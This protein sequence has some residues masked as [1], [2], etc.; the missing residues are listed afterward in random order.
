MNIVIS[1]NE[2]PLYG[3]RLISSG[4]SGSEFSVSVVATRPSIPI[5]GMDELLGDKLRWIVKAG[6]KSWDEIGLPIPDLFFQAGWYIDS[7]IRLGNEV[8]AKGG[9]VILLSDNCWR[10]TPRQWAGAIKYRLLY[11]RQFW[12]VWVPGKSGVKLMRTFG[13]PRAQIFDGLY[14]SDP[15]VFA[16]GPRLSERPKQFIFVGRLV[17]DKAVPEVAHAFGAFRRKFPDWSL[18]VYG[19]GPCVKYFEGLPGVNVRSFAQPT[20]VADAMRNSRFLV[21][22][23]RVD[24]WPLVVSEASLSGC[25]LVLSDCVGNA[26]EFMAETAGFVCRAGSVSSLIA[27][28]SRAA[29]LE[30]HSLDNI[31]LTARKL[32]LR[33]TPEGWAGRFR[34]ILRDAGLVLN[35]DANGKVSTA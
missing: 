29:E 22:P 10:N 27:A 24:H 8:R 17:S 21:L 23:S 32:G 3:A 26:P 12:G 6:V 15:E 20:E 31:G 13:V 25:G 5:K 4:I 28:L 7:F 30:G 33:Y 9:K 19:N 2:L 16:A 11:S 1:W 18:V 34:E 35:A 14:G